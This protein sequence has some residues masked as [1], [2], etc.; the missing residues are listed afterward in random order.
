MEHRHIA[1]TGII[2]DLEIADS[3]GAILLVDIAHPAGLIATGFLNDP[4]P[5]CHIITRQHIR[6][7]EEPRGGIIM[8]GKDFDNP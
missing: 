5:H 6:L 3:V 7:Y 8:M 2:K 4:V 1:E